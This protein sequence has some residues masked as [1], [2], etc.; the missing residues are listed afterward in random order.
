MKPF[1]VVIML[2]MS[3]VAMADGYI[4]VSGEYI[5]ET[6]AQTLDEVN[7]SV[8]VHYTLTPEGNQHPEQFWLQ[9]REAVREV[10]M[11]Y[12]ACEAQHVGDNLY[13][14]LPAMVPEVF[15]VDNVTVTHN[16]KCH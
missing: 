16:A 2:L 1:V 14:V 6:M 10:L 8:V 7:A 9:V 3:T 15:H 13:V 5:S 11:N 12:N 4:I